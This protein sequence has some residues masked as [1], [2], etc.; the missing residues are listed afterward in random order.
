LNISHNDNSELSNQ[1]KKSTDIVN[2][3]NTGIKNDT[4]MYKSQIINYESEIQHLK[5]D[6][7]KANASY[8]AIN[9]E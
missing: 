9:E 2:K 5:L 3:L 7:D 1:V 6:I 8:D 4:E